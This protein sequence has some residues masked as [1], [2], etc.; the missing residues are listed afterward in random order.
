M[1]MMSNQKNDMFQGFVLSMAMQAMQHMGK[2]MN[3]MTRKVERHMDAAQ[4]AIDLLDMLAE[5]TKGN[6]TEDEDKMLKHVL[7]DLKLNYVEELN[8]GRKDD[9]MPRMDASEQAADGKEGEGA[10]AAK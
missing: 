3:P 9:P 4:Q 7:G 2:V 10:E 5:K 8:S 6:L 1:W